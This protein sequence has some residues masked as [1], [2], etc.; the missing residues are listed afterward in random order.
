MNKVPGLLITFLIS[1]A[2]TLG[3]LSDAEA[4]R[5]GGARSFGGKSA[6]RMPYKR[7]TAA[8]RS[9]S[10]QRAYTQN[11]TT[12][13]AMSRRGGLMGM[14]GGL[15]LGGLLGAMFFGGA[16]EGLNFFDVLIFG[17]IAFMLYKLF[18][19]R[20]NSA[21]HPA[22]NKTSHDAR[23]DTPSAYQSPESEREQV[24]SRA[25]DTDV[26]FDKKNNNTFH[27]DADF[28]Q[29]RIPDDFDQTAFLSGAKTAF[30]SLQVAWDARDLAEIRGLTTDKVFAEIQ[31]QL[32]A[33]DEAN[34]TE[35]L[36]LEAELLEVGDNS[37]ELQATVLFD[38]LIREAIDRPA[39]QIREVWHFIKAKNSIQPTWYLDGIQQLES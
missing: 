21:R 26:L 11:Q 7:S 33:T 29:H 30:R 20:T 24:G 17:G 5:F 34:N 13:Q 18:A 19:A 28:S 12:R 27:Q 10:Q 39:E 2:L 1:C 16:F 36:E 38:G 3:S 22:Y 15:A 31:E 35:V 6:Y 14:L 37:L 25:F 4:K 32:K 9:A 8:P 23:S